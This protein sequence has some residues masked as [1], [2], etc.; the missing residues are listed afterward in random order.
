MKE[1]IKQWAERNRQVK[2][3]KSRDLFYEGERDIAYVALGY[4][5]AMQDLILLIDKEPKMH[6]D[7]NSV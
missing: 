4:Y 6:D 5:N 7:D 3:M 1:K 2:L